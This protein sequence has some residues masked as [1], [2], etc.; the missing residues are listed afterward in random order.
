MQGDTCPIEWYLSNSHSVKLCVCP[1]YRMSPSIWLVENCSTVWCICCDST[2]YPKINFQPIRTCLTHAQFRRMTIG[3]VSF[4]WTCI[5]FH[6]VSLLFW[7]QNNDPSNMKIL[8]W[9]PPYK[10]VRFFSKQSYIQ[11]ITPPR[12]LT[13]QIITSLTKQKGVN[14]IPYVNRWQGH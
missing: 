12:H 13:R 3:H 4:H 8:D 2:L 6:N 7:H 1:G 5:A 14:N 9:L 11:H 10:T